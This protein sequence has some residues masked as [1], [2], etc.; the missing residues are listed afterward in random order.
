MG[1]V[2]PGNGNPRI[3]QPGGPAERERGRPRSCSDRRP[4]LRQIRIA[5][6][7]LL[8]ARSFS[9]TVV[10]TLALAI[11]AS[12]AVF[13]VVRGVLLAP[14][15]FPESGRLVELFN[16]YRPDQRPSQEV[17]A[18]EYRED[19][20]RLRSF[21]RVGAWATAGANLTTASQPVHVALGLGTASLLPTLGLSPE[22]GRWFNADEETPGRD[23]IL[24]LSHALWRSRFGGDA[25]AVGKA[26]TVDNQPYTVVSVL[27]DGF[28]L[29]DKMD[30]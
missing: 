17:A 11:G 22:L 26:V 29:P 9:L 24:V 1:R 16:W 10:V 25:A 18:I 12:T 3:G 5:A 20:S 30:A 19:Y 15:P 27:P 6:R 8:R 13:S 7:T 14:F 4:M 23:R 2:G 28:E 21:S